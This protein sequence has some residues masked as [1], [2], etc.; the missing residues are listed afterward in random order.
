MYATYVALPW[1]MQD[2]RADWGSCARF[3]AP[4]W[5]PVLTTHG[6]RS[7]SCLN[8]PVCGC[9]IRGQC[10]KTS[11]RAATSRSIA[12]VSIA[13]AT[14]GGEMTRWRCRQSASPERRDLGRA[15][16]GGRSPRGAWQLPR[17]G[18]GPGRRLRRAKLPVR[19][20]ARRRNAPADG[21]RPQSCPCAELPAGGV[22]S[23]RHNR[24]R[25]MCRQNAVRCRGRPRRRPLPR[26][27]WSRS[28]R[29]GRAARHAAIAAPRRR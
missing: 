15:V 18:P 9:E 8:R 25:G 12:A 20:V 3:M 26:R 11:T 29:P 27:G 4:D 14:D 21:V 10:Q 6:K 1:Y 19:E 17:A 7:H 5:H 22:A 2:V 13:S 28:A 23:A 16:G 24:F